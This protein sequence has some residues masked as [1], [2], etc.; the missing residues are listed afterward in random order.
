MTAKYVTLLRPRRTRP[1]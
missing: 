1:P